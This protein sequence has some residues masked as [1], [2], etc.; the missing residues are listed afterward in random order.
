MKECVICG[1]VYLT[2]V[3]WAG[4]ERLI[5]AELDHMR[6]DTSAMTTITTSRGIAD[7]HEEVTPVS[8]ATLRFCCA[9]CVN[10]RF[11]GMLQPCSQQNSS[12]LPMCVV[13]YPDFMHALTISPG[14]FACCR[15]TTYQRFREYEI[16]T[17]HFRLIFVDADGTYSKSL[18]RVC[19]G[20][21]IYTTHIIDTI[22]NALL[23]WQWGYRGTFLNWFD[24]RCNWKS[25]SGTLSR[26][27]I[28]VE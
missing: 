22:S 14:F 5:P 19:G 16:R 28:A 11:Q 12:M 26:S 21:P 23:G 3:D 10:H 27:T 1:N 17:V 15:S 24:R 6:S 9:Y 2:E 25:H 20:S 13:I 7:G 8:S 18:G 4:R